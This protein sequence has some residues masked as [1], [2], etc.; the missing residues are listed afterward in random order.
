MATLKL[1]FPGGRYHATPTGHHVNEGIVEWPPS[2]WRLIRGLI[3]CGFT[4]QHWT[5]LPLIARHL[6]E[7]LC[8][9]LPEYRLPDAAL[10]HTR[11]YMP[12]TVLD[13]GRERTT[14][15]LD[16]FT[17]VGDG[18]LW[19]RWPIQLGPEAAALFSTL[20]DHLGYLGRS[21]SWVRAEVMSDGEPLPALGRAF[22]YVETARPSR[23]YEQIS[24]VAPEIPELYVSWRKQEFEGALAT[25]DDPEHG[26]RQPNNAQ[27]K[28]R[29]TQLEASYPLDV[30]DGML[31]DTARWKDAKWS[32][33][34]GSR[35][36][37]YWR[38]TGALAVAPPSVSRFARAASVEA[39][40]FAI[41][42]P[43]GSRSALPTLDRTV[44]QADLL[45][46]ALVSKS[47]RTCP[48]LSGRAVDGTPLRGHN[49]AHILPLDLARD[50]HLDHIL[51][52]APGKLSPEAMTAARS[53]K[54]TY[55][56][57]GAGELQ[58][59]IAGLGALSDLC[60]L[61]GKLGESLAT[62]LGPSRSWMSAT[63]FVPPRFLKKRGP[64]SLEGQV[65]AE[66]A[67][68]SLG[69]ATVELVPWTS[70]TL[71]LR[72]VIRRRGSK[73]PQ[74]FVDVGFILRLQFEE[75]VLGPICLGYGSHFGLG[76]FTVDG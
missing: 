54:R 16:A 65:H 7:S 37:L 31:W 28:K 18:E 55:M 69:A 27:L 45:H 15:V 59:A 57:G 30:L 51:L 22:P 73:A 9:V 43:S 74:P 20:A 68:R 66:L 58:V 62:L 42:T 13:K 5:G 47:G 2:P 41:T 39:L 35:R 63:P 34:P 8:S 21:E 1:K 75:P 19:V 52:F 17:D 25:M 61:E 6:F 44:P 53:V 4:T 36:V 76:R 23:G 48:E 56:K 11:H 46:R 26:K 14:L 49:H 12:T 33:A 24:L 70:E 64:N 3:A 60:K 50:R 72:H 32:Q 38:E 10:G 67:V 40:L 71:H 29:Q